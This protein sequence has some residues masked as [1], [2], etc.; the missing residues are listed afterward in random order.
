LLDKFIAKYVLCGKCKYPEVAHNAQKKELVAIC[1]ACGYA[2][3]MDVMH[4]A[5]K[6]LFKDI[7]NYYKNNPEFRGKQS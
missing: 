2:K 7:P 6:Q 3:K 1:N 4:K 5:G